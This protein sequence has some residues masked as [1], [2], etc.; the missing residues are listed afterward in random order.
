MWIE[1]KL[2][3]TS[4]GE[5]HYVDLYFSSATFCFAILGMLC[6]YCASLSS[7]VTSDDSISPA[8]GLGGR[9]KGPMLSQMFRTKPGAY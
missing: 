4:S 5:I 2:P 3:K 8:K 1:E 6:L 9:V 7:S